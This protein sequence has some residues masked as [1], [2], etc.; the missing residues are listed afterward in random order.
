LVK[1]KIMAKFILFDESGILVTRY[2]S[3]VH[4]DAIPAEAVQVSDEQ[5]F[6]TINE[7]D[8]LWT[9]TNEGDV[10]KVPFPD[11]PAPTLQQ[12]LASYEAAVQKHMNEVANQYGYDDVYTAISY[13]TEPIV[14]KFQTEGIAFREWR[15]LVWAYCIQVQDDCLAEPPVRT[16]PTPEDLILELPELIMPS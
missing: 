4:G 13:A 14:Q 10:V 16:P 12:V 8:G 3:A 2:D 15:S 6:Q 11:P 7:T 9:I 1:G 5:F